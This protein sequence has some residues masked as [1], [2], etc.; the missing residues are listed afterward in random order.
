MATSILGTAGLTVVTAG[1]PD[2]D[3]VDTV[4][5]SV[6][7]DTVNIFGQTN[8]VTAQQAIPADPPAYHHGDLRSALI[9]A[10]LGLVTEEQDWTFSL[11]E[12]ARRAGVSHNAPYNHFAD[13]RD[14]LA[15]VAVVGFESLGQRFRAATLRIGNA[16]TAL[17]RSAVAYVTF[18]V[19][20][21]AHYRL[22]FG[23]ALVTAQQ[24]RPKAVVEAGAQSRAIMAEI[25][26]RGAA[27]GVFD[28]AFQRD[29]DLSV[30]ALSAWSTVHGL[31]MLIIDGIADVPRSDVEAVAKRVAN[32]WCD[33]LMRR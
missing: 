21:P 31:T 32:A 12:V 18:G 2:A 19:D 6:D 13:K 15:A 28:A 30:A 8:S 3:D 27:D 24:G 5:L 1:G 29:E 20:N 26:R 33:G 10:A 14:L 9:E 22:M 4:N 25:I 17:A 16:R 23:S 11:R 7:M